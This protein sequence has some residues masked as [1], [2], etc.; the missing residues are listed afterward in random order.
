MADRI[1]ILGFQIDNVSMNEAVSVIENFIQEKSPHQVITANSL[2]L[3][4][5]I[6]EQ[7]LREVFLHADLVVADSSG[8]VLAGKILGQYFKERVAGIDLLHKLV[9][10]CEQKKYSIFLFGAQPGVAQ[11]AAG[12]LKKRHPAL[13]IAGTICG[14]FSK[15]EEEK[16]RQEIRDAQPDIL[17]VGLNIPRQ[18]LWIAQNLDRLAVP[19]CMGIGGSF[20]VI[21]ERVRRAP[22]S[23][24]YLGLEW[25]WRMLIEPWRIKR[26]ILLPL[27]LWQVWQYKHKKTKF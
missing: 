8:I 11:R 1:D 2:M 16:I 13:L 4:K 18:E 19:V 10:H 12:N 3:L 7:K 9:E 27:F 5:A 24:Q 20:D 21:S 22:R 26:I 25:F 23:L 14:Y 17:F 15:D 6:E